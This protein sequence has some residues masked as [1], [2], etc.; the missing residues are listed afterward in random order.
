ME[1]QVVEVSQS[2]MCLP[3]LIHYYDARVVTPQCH[4]EHVNLWNR[5]IILLLL[6]YSGM[7]HSSA[8]LLPA[9]QLA[10]LCKNLP[11][12]FLPT[13]P[14]LSRSQTTSPLSTV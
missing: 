8:D 5:A 13:N 6:I 14:P 7:S 2:E 3:W 12:P 10:S 1:S 4:H 9:R 11:Y